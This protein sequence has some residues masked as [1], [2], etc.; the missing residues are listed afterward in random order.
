VL[1]QS[2]RWAAV[3]DAVSD[4]ERWPGERMLLVIDDAHAIAGTPAESALERF[5]DYA[6]PSLLTIIASRTQPGFNL[7]RLRVSGALTEITGE[8]L[9][10]RSWEVENLF[11]DFYQEPL[12][13]I[14]L[15][16]L[17]RRTEGWAAGLQL[18][19]L[20]TSGKGLDERRRVLRALGGG[21][22]LVREYLARNVLDE[23]P[24]L[25]RAFLIETCVLGRLSGSICNQFLNR[26]DSEQL[27]QELE[28]RQIFTT[29]MGSDGDY[30]YHEV[31]RSHLEHVLVSDAGERALSVRYGAAGRVLEHFGAIPE[32]LHA[33]CRAE[34]WTAVD[35]LLGRNGPQL[36]RRTGVWIDALPPAVLEHDP[37]LLLASAR[38]HRAEGRWQ[39]AIEAYQRAEKGFIGLEATQ[40]CQRERQALALWLTPTAAP[41][42]DSMG[43]L[44][45][46]T[47]RDP[48]GVRMQLAGQPTGQDS[49][50]AGL[51]SLLAGEASEAK[52]LLSV[53][54]ESPD[55]SDSVLAGAQLGGALVSLMAGARDAAIELE[56]AVEDADSRGQGFIAR[57]GR[58]CAALIPGATGVS[59]AAAVRSVCDHLGDQWGA[60]LA[61][62]LEGLSLVQAGKGDVHTAALLTVVADKFRGLGAGVLEAW[63]RS[64]LAL[65][66]AQQGD[67][68]AQAAALRAESLAN[69]IAAEGPKVFIYL[70]LAKAGE[71]HTSQFVELATAVHART[72]FSPEILE[73]HLRRTEPAPQHPLFIRC[74]G[75][76][77]I[78]INGEAVVMANMKP[79][80]RALL[81]RLCAD[82]GSPIHREVLQDALWP[83]ADAEAAAR[84]LHVAISSLRQALEP[85]IARGASSLL[86]REGDTYRLVLP[87]GSEVDLRVFDQALERSRRARLAGDFHIAL[88]AFQQSAGIAEKELLPEEGSADW[89]IQRRERARAGLLDI[90]RP[91]ARHLL[92]KAQPALAA[93]VS[94]SAL[95][96]DRY[97][98]ELW[99][100]LIEARGKAGDEAGARRAQAEYR[101]IVLELEPGPTGS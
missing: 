88:D 57:L 79:R 60:A 50:V 31:L 82:A 37:W 32:A 28:R 81:R 51:A 29:A 94:V 86:I 6:P 3:E 30:R 10:F 74:F 42:A 4:L 58:A 90:A 64:L 16:E 14:E 71:G 89:V 48:L 83:N 98:D 15:A 96:A 93:Q 26:S 77:R 69:S 62:L 66:L 84:N 59:E 52:R 7:S 72:G 100:T 11:R 24:P 97:D 18:F 85:G 101:R 95:N 76:F 45:L 91:L 56:L 34:D 9:R 67:P 23:L 5:I 25:L 13:P 44:R 70:A 19:H 78:V 20:A 43:L 27:L 53:A 41:A 54:A 12:P 75:E 46:A 73:V 33:Y 39:S 47:I 63:S 61:A 99:R 22:R 80:A 40:I 8:D 21:S 55:E 36:A 68:Q 1:G 35:R 65:A 2:H 17:A 87:P 92:A 38:R 49:L